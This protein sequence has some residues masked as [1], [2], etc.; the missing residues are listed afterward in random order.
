MV[1]RTVF[2]YDNMLQLINKKKKALAF[3]LV[4]S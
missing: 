2:F 4:I 3:P 1:T